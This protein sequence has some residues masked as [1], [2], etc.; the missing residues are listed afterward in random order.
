MLAHP[1]DEKAGRRKRCHDEERHRDADEERQQTECAGD[2][3]NGFHNLTPSTIVNLMAS[4]ARSL[5]M[6]LLQEKYKHMLIHDS[7]MSRRERALA[8]RPGRG[9]G[10][11]RQWLVCSTTGHS[12][13]APELQC[14]K[15]RVCWGPAI[16]A[17]GASPLRK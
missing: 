9:A 4:S 15:R 3:T 11:P 5:S 16:G 14:Q 17:A 2:V 12:P 13:L 1:Q 7:E 10:T 6:I 8:E